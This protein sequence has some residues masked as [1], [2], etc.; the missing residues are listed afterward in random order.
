MRDIAHLSARKRPNVI[1]IRQR[2]GDLIRL[3]QRAGKTQLV[4]K[5][6]KILNQLQGSV[7]AA[8]AEEATQALLSLAGPGAHALRSEAAKATAAKKEAV[9]SNLS[10]VE[11][12]LA[13]MQG[14]ADPATSGGTRRQTAP[15]RRPQRDSGTPMPKNSYMLDNGRVRVKTGSFDRTYSLNDPVLTGEMIN[16]QSS[17]VHSI[18]FKMN[19]LAPTKS[20]IYVRYLGTNDA[21]D[22]V[23]QGPLY[24]YFGIHPDQFQSFVKAGS[25]GVWVWDH[26]RVRGSRVQHQYRYNLKAIVGGYMPRRATVRNGREMLVKR[27][28]QTRS[29]IGGKAGRVVV[30]TLPEQDLGPAKGRPRSGRPNR[31]R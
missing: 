23:G 26:L 10:R 28:R 15:P 3:A 19:F 29:E 13:A 24:E 16:V 30:S 5:L 9:T 25:K 21:G 22:R 31:G 8:A 4:T 20:T 12:L 2:A 14:K 1:Q 6:R 7:T 27:R 18:G 17:N 11:R